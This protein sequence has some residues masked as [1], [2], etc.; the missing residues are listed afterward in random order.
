MCQSNF[1]KVTLNLSATTIGDSNDEANFPHTLL[2]TGTIRSLLEVSRLCKAFVNNSSSNIK[3]SKTHLSKI[4]QSGG[5]L[6]WSFLFY[7]NLEN[8][9][10]DTL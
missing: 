7:T 8:L 10:I 3:L 4:V 5:I 1:A 9:K 6:P 2:L